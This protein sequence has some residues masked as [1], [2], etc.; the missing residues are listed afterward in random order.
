[1]K[2]PLK[3]TLTLDEVAEHFELSCVP[4]RNMLWYRLWSTKVAKARCK[5]SFWVP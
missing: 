2:A 3:S 4:R 5:A 1:M